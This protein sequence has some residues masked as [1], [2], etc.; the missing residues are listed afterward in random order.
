MELLLGTKASSTFKELNSKNTPFITSNYITHLFNTG[1]KQ[2]LIAFKN[3]TPIL[4]D[5][6]LK[7]YRIIR[8]HSNSLF[9]A[10]F[11][12]SNQ[13]WLT[14]PDLGITR[15]DLKTNKTEYYELTPP[16]LRSITDDERHFFYEDRHNQ[17][18]IGLHGSGLAAYNRKKQQFQILQKQREQQPHHSIQHHPL[19]CRG[20]IWAAM[21]WN[22]P[23]YGGTRKSYCSQPGVQTHY[24]HGTKRVHHPKRSKIHT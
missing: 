19:H 11:D 2:I 6:N 24:P 10:Y 3:H 13:A 14:G 1:Q 5:D 18:W 21:A 20:S 4:V 9:S 8:F 15:L 17:L 16:N 7:D 12:R 23:I 22:R